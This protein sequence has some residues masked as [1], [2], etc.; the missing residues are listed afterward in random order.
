MKQLFQLLIWGAFLIGSQFLSG[1]KVYEGMVY[2]RQSVAEI[3]NDSVY[4]EMDINIHGLQVNN[5]ESL[6]LYPT[7]FHEADSI[8]LPPVILYGKN[9]QRKVNR[10]IALEGRYSPQE[11]AYVV[12]NNNPIIHQ[13]VT[14]SQTLACSPWMKEAGLKLI[15]EVRDMDDNIIYTLSDTLTEDL[16][17]SN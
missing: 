6:S 2:V 7:L 8:K 14:Y 3:K 15:G 17:L 10:T 12:L 13:V 9:K 1:Q 5:R 11:N 16:R 4:L